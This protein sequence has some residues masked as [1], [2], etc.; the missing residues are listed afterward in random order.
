MS[1]LVTMAFETNGKG[2]L[3]FLCEYPGAFV[4][5]RTIDEALSKIEHELKSY[6]KWRGMDLEEKIIPEVIQIHE[7]SLMVE[8]GDTEILLDVDKEEI[9]PEEFSLLIDLVKKS[10]LTTYEIL[11]NAE[12]KDWIDE[13][14]IRKTFY[15]DTPKTIREIFEHIN[16]VQ[17]YYL[18]RLNIYME[19]QI[20]FLEGRESCIKEITSLF[21][22]EGNSRI[23]NI[24]NEKWTIKKVLRR[25]IWHDRIHSRS[26]VKILSKQKNNGIIDGY[27]DPFYFF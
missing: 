22:K 7:S 12:F 23:Y 18:S 24:D 4:R 1:K 13:D 5:G 15:G 21:C 2:C 16:S 27:K 26:M 17:Y 25:F 10:G 6:Q 9:D 19:R 14:R 8:D 11:E 3:G 20:D